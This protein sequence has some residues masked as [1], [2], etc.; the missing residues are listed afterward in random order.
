MTSRCSFVLEIALRH[1]SV[2]KHLA[3]RTFIPGSAVRI[4]LVT[5]SFKEIAFGS[6]AASL[7][8]RKTLC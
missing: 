6:R 7:S 2:E 8:E 1:L 3:G 5:L 4:G